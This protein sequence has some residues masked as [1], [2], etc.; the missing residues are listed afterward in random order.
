MVTRTKA[1]KTQTAQ[2]AEKITPV[3][4]TKDEQ[5]TMDMLRNFA[6]MSGIEIPS[7]RRMLASSVTMLAVTAL[8]AYSTASIASYIAVGAAVL[9]GSAFIAFLLATVVAVI[10]IYY[11]LIT[12]SRAAEY[13][14]SGKLEEHCVAAKG[15]IIGLFA[16]KTVA[17]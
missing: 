10:S 1:T 15:Y 9:T 11:T 17:G 3:I 5:S 16:T 4:D 7:G 12:A 13:V 2:A 8:G 6:A 14:G